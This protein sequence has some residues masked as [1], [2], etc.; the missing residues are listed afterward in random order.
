MNFRNPIIVNFLKRYSCMNLSTKGLSNH[1]S[2]P[3]K[4]RIFQQQGSRWASYQDLHT[5]GTPIVMSSTLNF[6]KISTKQLTGKS[7]HILIPVSCLLLI[8]SSLVSISSPP[9]LNLKY[10]NNKQRDMNKIT[11]LA[12]GHH[13]HLP[14]FLSQHHIKIAMDCSSLMVKIA[15]IKKF[16][17][18][19]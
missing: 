9:F 12:T 19:F 1:R 2:I 11:V 14:C 5:K 18:T 6:L 3:R 15:R 17:L 10:A 7:F 4:S 13:Y 8:V 16:A